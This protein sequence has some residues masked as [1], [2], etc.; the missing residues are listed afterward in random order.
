MKVL[1]VADD[2]WVINDVLTAVTDPGTTLE[3]LAEPRRAAEVAES[4]RPDIIAVDLQV[5]NMGGMAIV[6]LLSD[7]MDLGRTPR[8]PVV[9]LLDRS[10][11][12][13][14]ARRSGADAFLVKPF[15]GQD[16]RETILQLVAPRTV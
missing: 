4:T 11:D 8:V 13:F 3:T 1:L 15:T 10:A 9:L 16:L 5:K 14:L 6:R 2:G 12:T 7:A